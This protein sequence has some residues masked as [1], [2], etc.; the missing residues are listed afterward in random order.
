MHKKPIAEL[1]RDFPKLFAT[2][3]SELGS[4]GLIKHSIDTQGK[5]P[6][7]L[8]PYWT[9]RKQKEKLERQIKEMMATNVIE[10]STSPWAAPV[11]LVEKKSGELF[12]FL[13][14]A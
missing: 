14:F 10:H 5:G 12:S 13:D 6:I 3:N 8:R 7:R 2:K 9:G 11:I 4:T 1:L